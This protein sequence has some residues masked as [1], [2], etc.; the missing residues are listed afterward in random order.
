M[1][2]TVASILVALGLIFGVSVYE[3]YQVD[4]R[5]E[6]FHR[7]LETLHKKTEAGTVTYEDGDAVRA[8]W[9]KQKDTLHIWLPHTSLQEVDFQ[10]NEAIGFIYVNDYEGA[11]PKIEV[12]LGLSHTIPRSYR[13]RIEN[14]L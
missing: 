13:F 7:A 5:F 12:L 6:G 1:I 4:R 3:A 8:Y 10:L 14:V 9:E 11:L 2:R